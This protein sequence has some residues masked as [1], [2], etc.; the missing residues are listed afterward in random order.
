VTRPGAGEKLGLGQHG[1]VGRFEQAPF[2]VIE[3]AGFAPGTVGGDP[4]CIVD[5]AP[6]A[7]AHLGVP[8]DGMD[9]RALQGR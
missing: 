4:T 6:T 3:G 5:I 1:G 2:L 8:A 9:G 7:L